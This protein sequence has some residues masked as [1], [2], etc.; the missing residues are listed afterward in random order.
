MRRSNKQRADRRAAAA[1]EFAVILPLVVTLLLGAVELG[2]AV[3]VQ[4]MLQES[5]QAGCRLYSVN[6]PELT[7]QAAIDIIDLAMTHAG[8]DNYEIEFDPG[9]RRAGG[10]RGQRGASF[11]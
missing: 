8:I 3:S 7:K 10:D 5:A 6:D 1:V 9:S 11:A 2:R 4:H